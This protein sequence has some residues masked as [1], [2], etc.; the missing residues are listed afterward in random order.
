MGQG[1]DALVAF[2]RVSSSR[3]ET[4][5]NSLPAGQ[6]RLATERTAISEPSDPSVARRIFI[7]R[8][9]AGESADVDRTI[10]TEQGAERSTTCATLPRKNR[11]TAPS[12]RE[13][14][15]TRSAFHP[16][17]KSGIAFFG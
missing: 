1:E 4:I 14:T 8:D 17:A 10:S 7:E 2:S 11:E 12:P 5:L 15:F 16:R 6:G 3:T 13:P 9:E